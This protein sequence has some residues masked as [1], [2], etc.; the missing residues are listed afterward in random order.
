MAN[1]II[2]NFQHSLSYGSQ[3]LI[4]AVKA[5]ML[6]MTQIMALNGLLIIFKLCRTVFHGQRKLALGTFL[7]YRVRMVVAL[8]VL[9]RGSSTDIAMKSYKLGRISLMTMATMTAVMTAVSLINLAIVIAERRSRRRHH[10]NVPRHPAN[11]ED[12]AAAHA[13]LGLPVTDGMPS[14]NSGEEL[15]SMTSAMIASAGAGG[16]DSGQAT[17]ARPVHEIV[18]MPVERLCHGLSTNSSASIE[19]KA[20]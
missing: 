2:T 4:V 15:S 11:C 16:T 12:G 3:I 1:L 20:V 8:P 10:E 7:A 14:A 17:H 5:A 13:A 9:S 19:N 18:S 6:A